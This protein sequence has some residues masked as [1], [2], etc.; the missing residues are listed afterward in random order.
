MNE[1]NAAINHALLLNPNSSTYNVRKGIV[2]G[3]EGKNDDAEI[4]SDKGLIFDTNNA[5]GWISKGIVAEAKGDKAGAI[6]YY[7]EAITLDP[8]ETI[9]LAALYK[10]KHP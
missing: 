4:Y 10:L 9:T 8:D 2:L 6:F 3:M 1:D 5:F 7:N